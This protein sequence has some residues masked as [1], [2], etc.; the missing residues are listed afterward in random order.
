M[1]QDTLLNYPYVIVRI[2]CSACDRA[3]SYRLARLAAK[4]GADIRLDDLLRRLAGD[5]RYWCDRPQPRRFRC[6]ARFCDID[7]PTRPPDFPA[8]IRR[9][10]VVRGSRS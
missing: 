4:Y 3:G 1:E 7:P 8:Q 5:C 9:I 6:M 10:R 2:A